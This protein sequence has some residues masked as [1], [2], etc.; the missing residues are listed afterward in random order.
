MR[1]CLFGNSQIIDKDL[2][3]KLRNQLIY[4]IEVK[5][6]Y[7]FW[8][9]GMG[10]FDRLCAY[11]LRD[12]KKNYPQI[13]S[14]LILAYLKEKIDEEWEE[15]NNMYDGT[16]YPDLER[17]PKRVVIA[18]RNEIMIK[19]CNYFI[20]YV[21]YISANARNIMNKVKKSKKEYINLGKYE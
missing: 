11:I 21:D 4:V 16:I 2:E 6:I 9:G 12:L 18:K 10:A 17:V 13:K 5:K 8:S 20:L 14:Y 15:V 3:R 1:C 19:E 7:E